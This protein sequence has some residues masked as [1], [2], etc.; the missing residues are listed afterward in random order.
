M[1]AADEKKAWDFYLAQTR[2]LRGRRYRLVEARA[3]AQ[4]Q[5]KRGKLRPAKPNR[6]AAV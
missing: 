2:N 4:L 5:A 6:K 3:W 1:D